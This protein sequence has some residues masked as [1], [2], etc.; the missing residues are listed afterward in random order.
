MAVRLQA[1]GTSSRRNEL[2]PGRRAGRAPRRAT[3]PSCPLRAT[4][5]SRR[6]RST[7][8]ELAIGFGL[9]A[10]RG[11]V[12]GA[13]LAARAAS[14][15]SA[16]RSRPSWAWS[17]RRCGIHDE[18]RAGLPRSTSSKVRG[19]EVAAGPPSWPATSLALDPGDAVGTLSGIPTTEPAFGI[20]A[21]VDPGLG[22]PPRPR[23]SASR[24]F[25]RESVIVTHLTEAIPLAR[26]RPWL[27]R[28]GRR[29]RCSTGS[30][31]RTPAVVDGGRP[32][33][34]WR[35]ARSSACLQALLREGV[36]I[37]DLGSIIEAIGVQ[38][39]AFN[40]ATPE[41][42][43][44]TPAPGASAARSSRPTSTPSA[45]CS[46]L[47]LEP[48]RRAGG[49][50][51]DHADLRRRV[52]GDGTGGAAQTLVTK[53]SEKAEE[54]LARGGR[55]P[56]LLCSGAACRPPPAPAVRAEPSAA[57]HML[58]Q[59]DRAG[60][61]RGKPLEWLSCGAKTAATSRSSGAATSR[62]CC[63]RS[64]SR[65]GPDAIITRPARRGLQG[66]L[67]RAF[68]QKQFV[69]V[70]GA[71]RGCRVCSAHRAAPRRRSTSTTTTTPPR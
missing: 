48:D 16:A 59:R 38:G 62:S 26:S 23:R 30:R 5:P 54:A 31:R 43:P 34:P 47:A 24:S 11:P 44:S 22:A 70:E 29:A 1:R 20:P 18:G 36:S 57:R 67:S 51:G 10:A 6:C 4:R 35:S 33:R 37:R 2:A 3:C 42:W 40:A 9:V 21:D 41:C 52:P 45:S 50:R 25:D 71:R 63:R 66:R 64:A 58:L 55:A 7:P 8:L 19:A 28:P 13:G 15:S 46:A 32:R 61:R 68:F 39:P 69:E 17:S 49:R 56:C 65:L 14:A 12:G 27:T 53:L 60:H